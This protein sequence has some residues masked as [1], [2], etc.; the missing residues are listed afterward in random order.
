MIAKDIVNLLAARHDG[1]VFVPECKDGPTWGTEHVRLD[2][3]VLNRSWSKHL[4]IGYEIKVSRADFMNDKKWC[5]YLPLCN[6][7]YFVCPWGL[8]GKSEV[9]DLC[10]LLYATKNGEKLRCVKKA[11]WRDVKIPESVYLYVLKIRADIE[12]RSTGYSVQSNSEYWAEWLANEESDDVLGRSV[13][14]EIN[15]RVTKEID[16][17]RNENRGLRRENECFSRIKEECEKIGVNYN[18]YYEAPSIAKQ[19]KDARSAIPESLPKDLEALAHS[20]QQIIGQEPKIR[21]EKP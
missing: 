19:L 21:K 15:E 9:P 7:L 1:D 4:I 12:K 16:K 18:A 17:V 20:L 13:A 8:I 2:A 5:N 11:P 14:K 10:G 3:W 6:E